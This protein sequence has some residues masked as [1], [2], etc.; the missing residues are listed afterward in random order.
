MAFCQLSRD[1]PANDSLYFSEGMSAIFSCP[2]KLFVLQSF[3][4]KEAL[5]PFGLT[6]RKAIPEEW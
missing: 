2:M 1:S 5:D 6:F 4:S 3:F